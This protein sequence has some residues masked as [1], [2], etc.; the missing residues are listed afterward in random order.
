MRRT[1][2]ALAVAIAAAAT[3]TACIGAAPAATPTQTEHALPS[4]GPTNPVDDGEV[5]IPAEASTES[6]VAALQAASTALTT[7]AQPDLSAA[8]WWK[9]MLPLLSQAAA[10]AY[11]GTDPAEIPVHQVTGP[12][13]ILEGSTEVSLIVEVPTDAGAYNVTLIRGDPTAPWLADRIRPALG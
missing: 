3:L 5:E 7:F 12:G 1:L 2:T 9:Q 4:T 8:E 13:R 11:E 6:G 10:I